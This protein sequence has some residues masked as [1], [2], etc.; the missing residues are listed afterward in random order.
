MQNTYEQK[1]TDTHCL[2]PTV[3]D[4]SLLMRQG[5]YFLLPYLLP[6]VSRQHHTVTHEINELHVFVGKH[7][8]SFLFEVN[9]SHLHLAADSVMSG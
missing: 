6:Q 5:G 3:S 7:Q 8:K 2:H 4:G 1:V 9:K